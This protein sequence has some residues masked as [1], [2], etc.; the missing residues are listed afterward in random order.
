MEFPVGISTSC[1]VT[2]PRFEFNKG[3]PYAIL[4]PFADTDIEYPN[5]AVTP[6]PPIIPAVTVVPERVK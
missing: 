2:C 6:A 5:R 4:E 3:E 1:T